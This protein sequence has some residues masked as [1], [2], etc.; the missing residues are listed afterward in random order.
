MTQE[1]QK[2]WLRRIAEERQRD[3]EERQRQWSLVERD[4]AKAKV[5]MTPQEM[6]KLSQPKVTLQA[7]YTPEMYT[8]LKLVKLE[9]ALWV[10]FKWF[11]WRWLT[12]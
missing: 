1:T 5:R 6:L 3:D 10:R 8:T 2:E 4:W 9:N 12:R 7:K 11:L